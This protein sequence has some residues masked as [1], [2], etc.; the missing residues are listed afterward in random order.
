MRV[1]SKGETQFDLRFKRITLD[2]LLR[3]FCRGQGQKQRD[4]LGRPTVVDCVRM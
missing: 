2:T 1:L 4:H 3:I